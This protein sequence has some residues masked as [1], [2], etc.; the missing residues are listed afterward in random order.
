LEGGQLLDSQSSDLADTQIVRYEANAL[1]IKI[2][3]PVEGYLVLSDPYYPGW[4][5][6]VD[7]RPAEI[8]RA[9]YAFRA[10]TVPAGAH[11]VSMVFRPASWSLG[12]AL[13]VLTVLVLLVGGSI[14]WLRRRNA[15]E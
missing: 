12:L 3:S 6:E 4:K 7:G 13:S 11:T 8:L 1:E 2:E 9:N 10:V 5:A 15:T 14:A